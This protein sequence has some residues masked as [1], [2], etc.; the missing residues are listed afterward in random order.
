MHLG[1]CISP[2]RGLRRDPDSLLQC[3]CKWTTIFREKVQ[4]HP[5]AMWKEDCPECLGGFN[6]GVMGRLLGVRNL[7]ETM[8]K[9]NNTCLKTHAFVCIG[10]RCLDQIS[11]G[12]ETGR[13]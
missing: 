4:M 7:P 3:F 10:N 11:E 12:F 8:S 5:E 13:S 1:L 6:L 9:N 2:G